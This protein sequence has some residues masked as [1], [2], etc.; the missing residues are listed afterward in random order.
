MYNLVIFPDNTN[1]NTTIYNLEPF[2]YY[3]KGQ[4]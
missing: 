4:T 1:A 2:S 3:G